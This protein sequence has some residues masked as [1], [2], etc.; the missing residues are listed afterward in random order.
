M[1]WTSLLI[2]LLTAGAAAVASV[3]SAS[4]HWCEAEDPATGCGPCLDGNH[5]HWW[6]DGGEYCQSGSMWCGK[7]SCPRWDW[8]NKW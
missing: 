5:E 6:K 4:A 1:R 2:G 8:T 7:W 3:P